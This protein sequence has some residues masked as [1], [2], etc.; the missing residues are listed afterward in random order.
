MDTETIL[1]TAEYHPDH[2][3]FKNNKCHNIIIAIYRARGWWDGSDL[4]VAAFF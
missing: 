3:D 4:P 2:L 1:N